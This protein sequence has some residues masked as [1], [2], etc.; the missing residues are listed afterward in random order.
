MASDDHAADYLGGVDVDGIDDVS[1]VLAAGDEDDEADVGGVDA[2]GEVVVGDETADPAAGSKIGNAELFDAPKEFDSEDVRRFL[3]DEPD[4][5]VL[6]PALRRLTTDQRDLIESF[7]DGFQSRSAFLEWCQD[8]CVRTLG[9]LSGEWMQTRAF[10][11]MDLSVLVVS[12][13]RRR[14]APESGELL[15]KRQAA[16]VRRGVVLA[17]VLPACRAAYRRLRWSATEYVQDDDDDFVPDPESQQHTAM[18][19]ALTEL[20]ERQDWA[21]RKLLAGLPSEDALLAW[22]QAVTEASYAEI[23]DELGQQLNRERRARRYLLDDV[24]DVDG[25]RGTALWFRESFASKFVLPAFARAASE[26]G[27]RAGELAEKET[28]EFGKTTL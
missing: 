26:V 28:T 21:I 11:R 19:P 9:E 25:D 13:A 27:R 18:R 16:G 20:D 14:F 3:S 15:S 1:T 23:P 8:A 22:L 12:D 4:S 17:D 7:V 5:D 24:D 2:P 6:R 10:T